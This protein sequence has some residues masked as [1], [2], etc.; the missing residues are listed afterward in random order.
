MVPQP[1]GLVGEERKRGRVGLGEAERG[2]AEQLCEHLL[3]GR[4][5]DAAAGGAVEEA[6]AVGLD[7]FAAALAAHR[8]AEPLRLAH[9]EAG[10]R[11]RDLE[12]LL[13][14]EDDAERLRAAAR[15]ADG[16]S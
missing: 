9:G 4:A 14:E 3:G 11:H 15:R 6:L 7:R 5:V 12:H 13:L 16:W 2:E 1:G 10:E 8:A